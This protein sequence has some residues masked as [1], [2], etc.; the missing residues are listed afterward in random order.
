MRQEQEGP[1][2]EREGLD[3]LGQ[4]LDG[5]LER[6]GPPHRGVVKAPLPPHRG[7]VKA[8]LPHKPRTP[9]RAQ[10]PRA[11]WGGFLSGVGA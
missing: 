3:G 1:G 8:P 5:D 2:D 6:R 9:P 4:Y 10:V 7:V 11:A